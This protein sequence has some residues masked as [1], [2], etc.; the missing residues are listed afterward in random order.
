MSLILPIRRNE[1]WMP[2]FIIRVDFY[3]SVIVDLNTKW[4]VPH[5]IG[6]VHLCILIGSLSFFLS[7][8]CLS[9]TPTFG[10]FYLTPSFVVLILLIF[11][12]V[13]FFL[14]FSIIDLL[15]DSLCLIYIDC[16]FNDC[17]FFSNCF[18]TKQ[19]F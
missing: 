2:K 15:F 19:K 9:I 11:L 16:Q 1:S 5:G 4:F 7:T 3:G 12:N 8:L 13:L 17:V 14:K 6:S 10:F 18:N